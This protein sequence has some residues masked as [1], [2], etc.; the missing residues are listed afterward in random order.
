MLRRFANQLEVLSTTQRRAGKLFKQYS[1]KDDLAL[2]AFCRY[3]A[4]IGYFLRMGHEWYLEITIT[5]L[6]M[7]VLVGG[8]GF[9]DWSVRAIGYHKDHS[10]NCPCDQARGKHGDQG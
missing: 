6:S 10:F 1:R 2:R 4:I 5:L 9:C 3:S 7:R 8:G